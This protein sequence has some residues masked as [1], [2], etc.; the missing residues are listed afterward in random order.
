MARIVSTGFET[1]HGG[2]STYKLYNLTLS[3]INRYC[4]NNTCAGCAE[5]SLKTTDYLTGE[6][7]LTDHGPNTNNDISRSWKMERYTARNR[8]RFAGAGTRVAASSNN[9]FYPTV[10]YFDPTKFVD[11]FFINCWFTEA[12]YSGVSSY[13]PLFGIYNGT[14]SFVGYLAPESDQSGWKLAIR[15]TTSGN[16]STLVESSGVVVP[17]SGNSGLQHLIAGVDNTGLM[18]VIFNNVS[19]SHDVSQQTGVDQYTQ[20]QKIMIASNASANNGAGLDDMAINDGTGATDNSFPPNIRG[21]SVTGQMIQNTVTDFTS[22]GGGDMVTEL[23]DDSSTTGITTDTTDAQI[24]FNLPALSGSNV[25]DQQDTYSKIARINVSTRHVDS[26][27]YNTVIYNTV[28]D[29]VTNN[30]SQDTQLATSNTSTQAHFSGFVNGGTGEW[31]LTNMI[32]GDY[33]LK[34]SLT[35]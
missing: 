16:V 18:T 2:H 11:G 35:A 15:E 5:T 3:E 32:N 10:M 26:N 9:A 20:W 14:K 25:N 19:I 29:T 31:N 4:L 1:I 7:D 8:T 6:W 13:F 23:T 21:Y 33:Q 24:T 17:S 34:L 28:T 12:S 27:R 30:T 22:I